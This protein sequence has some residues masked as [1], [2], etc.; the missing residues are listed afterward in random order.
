MISQQQPQ[1][2]DLLQV[3]TTFGSKMRTTYKTD[4]ML[5]RIQQKTHHTTWMLE[6]NF[7]PLASDNKFTTTHADRFYIPNETMSRP[8]YHKFVMGSERSKGLL[9]VLGFC[10]LHKKLKKE[11]QTLIWKNQIVERIGLQL[12]MVKCNSINWSSAPSYKGGVVNRWGDDWCVLCIEFKNPEN[13][14][15]KIAY[16]DLMPEVHDIYNETTLSNGVHEFDPSNLTHKSEYQTIDETETNREFISKHD[17]P[18]EN[19]TILCETIFKVTKE[20]LWEDQAVNFV[21]EQFTQEFKHLLVE[22]TRKFY[23]TFE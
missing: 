19:T 9:N 17:P 18:L 8:L 1:H 12:T 21:K 4:Q 3:L 11:N 13:D 6:D 2:E 23:S 20:V 10:M 22:E 14:S 15:T 16:F 7:D 5:R